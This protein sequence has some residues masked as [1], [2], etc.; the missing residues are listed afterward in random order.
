MKRVLDHNPLTGESVIF[1]YD[2]ATDVLKLTHQQNVEHILE[3][4]KALAS[5]ADRTKRQIK[6]DMVHYATVPNTVILKWQL[7]KG[8][9]VFNT[10]HRR[11]VFK[12][13]NDPDYKY[14]KTTGIY[15]DYKTDA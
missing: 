11:E 6:N 13:L 7:E 12:L 15:H 10:N 4:N 5:D 3:R 14:L 2:E 8:V 1:D 9:D